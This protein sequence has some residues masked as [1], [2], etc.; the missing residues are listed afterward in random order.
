MTAKPP[1]ERRVR[2]GAGAGYSGDRIEPAV[3]LAEHGQLDY[4][5]FECLAERTIALAQQ[6]RRKDPAL[7]YDPLLDARMHAVLPVAADKRVRIVSNMGAANPRAA[8]R[9]TARIA[10]SLGLAGLKVAAVEGD[11]VLDVVLRGAFRFEESGDEVAAYRDRIVSANAYLGAAPIVDALA[12]G[13]DVVLTGRVADPSLFAA[14]LIHAFGWRMDDWDTLGAATVVGHLL[15]C[16]GQVTGGY[17]ADPGYKDVPNL[18]R[19]GFPIGEVAADGSVV[20]TK[21][22]HAGGRVSAATCKEQLLYEIHDPARYLQPD[23]VADFTRVAVAE[24]AP[25]RVRV[26]GGRG[27]AR[28]GTLKVSVAYVDGHIGEGQIS[29]GGPG[30]L[31]RAR[32]AL[33][34]VR[35]RLALTG[36]AATELRFDLI[37]VDALYGDAT[38]AVRGEPAEVRVRVAGRAASAAEAA[39]I[40]NEVETLYTNGPAGG[41]GAFKSTR[42]V[43]AVQSVLLPRTAVTPSFSFV[44]A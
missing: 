37:G 42:E 33:D 41:G 18:A 17:F 16:A 29:Y 1:H 5:V 14:P 19:L 44:E 34:I 39:R 40:G 22:P 23:V 12:A 35:E 28:T 2:I 24:E 6:A 20:I 27:S 32:L 36:V 31:E 43:I 25:D 13:A 21:V 10:Q 3:E 11:D 30:A 7:G 9:R 38:P 4:L 15:E 26:T 8:A